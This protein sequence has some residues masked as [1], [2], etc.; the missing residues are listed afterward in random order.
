MNTRSHLTRRRFVTGSAAALASIAFVR[1]PARAATWTYRYASNLTVDHPLNVSMRQCWNAVRDET[2]GRLD[3]KMF[4]NSQLGGDT[5]VL[6]QLRSGAVQFFTLDAAF[7]KASFRLPRFKASVLR[8]RIRRCVSRPR[9]RA[10]RLRPQRDRR[11]SL[12]VHPKCGKTACVRSPRTRSRSARPTIS[13]TSLSVRRPAPCGRSVQ[14][15]RR[16]ADADQLQR[17]VHRIANENRRR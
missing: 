10:R 1:A 13:P 11:Q 3:V 12:Y 14:V 8:S 9:R 2:G 15:I 16:V 4:P 17:N 6:T 5:A 7:C